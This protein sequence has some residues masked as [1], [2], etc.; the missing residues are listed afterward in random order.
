MRNEHIINLIENTP[1]AS[2]SHDDLV[3]IQAHT[4]QCSDCLRAFQAAQISVFLL[5]ERAAEQ[6]E[7]SPFFNTR[8]L[9]ALRERQTANQSWTWS[10]L[11]RA[12]GALA[13]SMVATVATLAVLTFIIP[14]NQVAS[15]PQISS[16]SNSYSAEEVLL[17]QSEQL[18]EPA[19]DAQVLNTIYE[20]EAV[21]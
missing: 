13:S 18:S 20:E 8:V 10:P 17:N 4:E 21:R 15:G 12:A 14:G 19:S 11:W 5:K 7:P 16:L 3:A 2:L 6:L 1:L 9:A